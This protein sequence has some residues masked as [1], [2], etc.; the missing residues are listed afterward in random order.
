MPF[1]L[2][3]KLLCPKFVLV[4]FNKKRGSIPKYRAS[5]LGLTSC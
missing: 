3:L 5:L 1:Y 2:L 4:F